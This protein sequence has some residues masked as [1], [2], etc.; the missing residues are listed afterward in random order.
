[1]I[2]KLNSPSVVVTNIVFTMSWKER[3]IK[4][5]SKVNQETY[6]D[7]VANLLPLITGKPY[8]PNIPT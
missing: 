5:E 2:G 4:Y 1:S 7:V 3:K 8:N 6:D